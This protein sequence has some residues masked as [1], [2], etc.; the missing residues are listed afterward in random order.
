M[1]I[2]TSLFLAVTSIK[3]GNKGTLGMTILIMTLA[4]VNLVFVA[5]IFGG[6][7]EAINK[8]AIDNQYSNI[9]IE[10]AVDEIYIDNT[11]AMSLIS[12]IPGVVGVSEHYLDNPIVKYDKN[13]DGKD[14]KSGK[15]RIMVFV[16]YDR[17]ARQ[18]VQPLLLL[19]PRHQQQYRGYRGEKDLYA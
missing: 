11:R 2:K 19:L 15:F 10:P 1:N 5:S 9:V 17:I 14:I 16:F 12:T 4:Y 3:R 6:I 18:L 7:V 13:K 8:E